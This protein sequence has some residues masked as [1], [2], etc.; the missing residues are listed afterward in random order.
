MVTCAPWFLLLIAAPVPGQH[1]PPKVD[2]RLTIVPAEL[3]LALQGLSRSGP[4]RCTGHPGGLMWHP[5]V[6]RTPLYISR[7]WPSRLLHTLSSAVPEG[8]VSSLGFHFLMYPYQ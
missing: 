4:S 2:G 5:G 3:S 8:A 7:P 6:H 1:C